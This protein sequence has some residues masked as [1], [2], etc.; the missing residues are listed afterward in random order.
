MGAAIERRNAR[1]VGDEPVCD[2]RVRSSDLRGVDVPPAWVPR[3]IDEF[4]VLF[5]A[6]ATASGR[7][8]V[9]GAAELRVK[10]SDRLGVMADNLAALGI[11]ARAT[12]DGIEIEGGTLRGGEVASHG[13]HRIAMAFAVAGAVARG[14]VTV[15]DTANVATSFP[16][17]AALA[18]QTGWSV[19]ER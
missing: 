2:L 1:T 9:T 19:H 6:A 13:D 5:V 12:D 17:F 4:P 18:R 10:E 15:R 7:T 16:G 14:P 11:E 8:R 3:T